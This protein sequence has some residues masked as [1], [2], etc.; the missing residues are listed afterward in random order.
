MSWFRRKD[1]PEI[2]P[3][4]KPNYDANRNELL[5]PKGSNQGRSTSPAPPP[6]QFQ[7]STANTYVASRDGDPYSSRYQNPGQQQS[8]YGGGPAQDRYPPARG[9]LANDPYARSGGNVDADRQQLF[10]GYNPERNAPPR[11]RYDDQDGQDGGEQTQAQEEEDVEGIKKDLRFTK[12]ETVS[13]TRNALRMAR[14]AEETARGTLLRLGD[15]SEK[16]ANT[17]RH[18]DM[19]KAHAHRAEDRTEELKQLNR[20][21]FRPVITWNKDSKRAA[22]ENR[23]L[24]RHEEEREE[25]EKAMAD[26]RDSQNR[27]GRA[28]TYGLPG[29]PADQEEGVTSSGRRAKAPEAQRAR[30]EQRKRFQFEAT[31]SDDELEDELD[32]NLD[33]I[34]DVSKRLKA[35]AMAAGQ[36]VDNQNAR[37][38]SIT[39]KTTSLDNKVHRN[40]ERLKKIK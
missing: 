4:I 34:H 28:A 25:R 24:Q 15:Q 3:V 31:A 23:I 6:S 2:P 13:S 12:Q 38:D 22:E 40:T 5:G 35:L 21:I 37:L 16:I 29:E 33:E 11:R 36:E 10:S 17:E 32:D 27:I 26:V 39:Q 7:K 19:S 30:Q 1:T 8:S 14:E 20:S 9:N 18:L